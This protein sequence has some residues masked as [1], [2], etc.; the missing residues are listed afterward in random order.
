MSKFIATDTISTIIKENRVEWLLNKK[1][2]SVLHQRL[3]DVQCVVVH[4]G[5]EDPE[6]HIYSHNSS[7]VLREFHHV[8]VDTEDKD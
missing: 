7:I 1:V 8:C 4:P 2:F 5:D 6:Y 3:L